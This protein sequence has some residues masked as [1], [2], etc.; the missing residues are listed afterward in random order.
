MTAIK[1][2]TAHALIICF[3]VFSKCLKNKT[4]NIF[5]SPLGTK[6]DKK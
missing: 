4:L 1:K 5:F 3:F 6:N 2:Y